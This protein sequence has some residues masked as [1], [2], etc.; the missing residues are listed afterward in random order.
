[1]KFSRDFIDK[2]RD[3]NNIVDIISRQ[4]ELKRAGGQMLGLCPFPNHREKTPSFSVS[5]S[6]QLYYCFGCKEAGNIFKFVESIMGMSFPETVEWLARQAGIPIPEEVYLS[7]ERKETKEHERQIFLN[8][9]EVAIK[10]YEDE[11]ARGFDRSPAKDYLV[12]RGIRPETAKIFRLGYAPNEWEK[13]SSL[14][15][16]RRIPFKEAEILGLV[17]QRGGGKAGYYDLFRNRLIFPIFGLDGRCLGFGGRILGEGEPKYFN[18]A[19]SPLFHK[20]KVFYG[21]NETAKYIRAKDQVI[22]VEGYMDLLALFQLGIQ[23]VVALLG[24]ALTLD[25]ARLLKRFTSNVVVLFD[26]DQAGQAATE[27][28]LPTLLQAGL[29]PRGLT[30]SEGMDPDDFLRKKGS[31]ILQESLA[32]APELFIL[33]LDRWMKDYR[34]SSADKILLIDRVSHTLKNIADNR[35][36][37]LY[38]QELGDRLGVDENWLTKALEQSEKGERTATGKQGVSDEI[39]ICS[40]KS[41]PKEV[42][43]EQIVISGK[44][45]KAEEQL[46]NLAL[47][48]S[49]YLQKIGESGIIEMF[50]HP[51]LREV[52]RRILLLYGQMPNEFDKLTALLVSQVD[53]PE[54]LFQHLEKHLADLNSE[55]A[56]KLVEDCSRMVRDANLKSRSRQ[57]AVD[58]R[59]RPTSE[60]LEKLE[61]IMNIQLNRRVQK[62]DKETI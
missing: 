16:S 53:V 35:L 42:S 47:M 21:L 57:L 61:Q 31:K 7:G 8:I 50:S 20:G 11:L 39:S 49:R 3:A 46:V 22:V 45:P 12:K 55:E 6:K 19:E 48:S 37:D 29:F 41:L 25:H 14:L 36:K 62:I 44:R 51:G 32:A 13:L 5:E 17:R 43:E 2:V 30:L 9:N 52:L 38:L 24:T 26:G 27:R 1:M 10:F 28:S 56:H 59:G 34:G 23:N 54:V 4:T 18:S 15:S 40:S 58:L 60:Q 33:I